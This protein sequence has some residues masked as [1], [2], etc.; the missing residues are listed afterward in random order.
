MCDT[1]GGS[2]YGLDYRKD[3]AVDNGG[4]ALCKNEA[5]TDALNASLMMTGDNGAIELRSG[6]SNVQSQL[7]MDGFK[8]P[9]SMTE[10]VALGAVG[11]S[12]GG[13]STP[14]VLTDIEVVSK[15]CTTRD[16]NV[17]CPV[18][19]IATGGGCSFDN[20]S[21][22]NYPA[23]ID[24]DGKVDQWRC[25]DYAGGSFDD[26]TAFVICGTEVTIEGGG[27]SSSSGGGSGSCS[28][29][30][31][32]VEDIGGND[33]YVLGEAASLTKYCSEQGYEFGH[34]TE[35]TFLGSNCAMYRSSGWELF[36]TPACSY[37]SKAI[38]CS[39]D[40]SG[41]SSSGGG[42]TLE[43]QTTVCGVKTCDCPAGWLVT[44]GGCEATGRLE[45]SKAN[46]NG[47]ICDNRGTFIESSVTCARLQ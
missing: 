34:V 6:T 33:Y 9:N 20:Y 7:W 45:I 23:D 31:N 39:M 13:S 38:C 11:S 10:V 17:S 46:G 37:A 4:S 2:G 19:K 3:G 47:W 8:L 36:G 12:S 22:D 29:V 35:F 16:C 5:E 30:I 25:T 15:T 24:A 42:G 41:S 21:H 26:V 18:G 44:G 40:G 28:E 32:P 14:N 27:S 1:Y 43:T